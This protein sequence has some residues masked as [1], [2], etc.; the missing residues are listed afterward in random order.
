[1]RAAV[2][3]LQT[4][5]ARLQAQDMRDRLAR[6]KPIK[7]P[8][9]TV[10]KAAEKADTGKEERSSGAV[11]EVGELMRRCNTARCDLFSLL[12]SQQGWKFM[13]CSHCQ[14]LC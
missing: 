5:K 11:P 14:E 13:S 12:C 9:K 8:K 2:N 1:M 10:E 7:I 6:L 4:S 3:S